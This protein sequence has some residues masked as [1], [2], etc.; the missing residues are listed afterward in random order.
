VATFALIVNLSHWMLNV[1][2]IFVMAVIFSF[3]SFNFD[4]KY[5]KSGIIICNYFY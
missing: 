3:K 1:T 5:L 4:K 2:V